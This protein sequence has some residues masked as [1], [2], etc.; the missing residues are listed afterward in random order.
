MYGSSQKL[1]YVYMPISS[2]AYTVL[3]ARNKVETIWFEKNVNHAIA[4]DV[5]NR[6]AVLSILMDHAI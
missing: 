2:S 4:F 5:I 1:K 6:S 3:T